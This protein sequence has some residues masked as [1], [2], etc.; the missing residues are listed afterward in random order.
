[1]ME[2]QYRPTEGLTSAFLVD[3][4]ACH[5]PSIVTSAAFILHGFLMYPLTV[6]QKE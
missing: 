1:M 4:A 6:V 3:K 2:L 5:P